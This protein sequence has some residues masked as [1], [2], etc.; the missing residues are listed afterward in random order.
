MRS[1][2]VLILA[3]AALIG[4]ADIEAEHEH[5]HV[6]A[7]ESLVATGTAHRTVS[8]AAFTGSVSWNPV[9]AV[10][11]NA[12]GEMLAAVPA[13][14]GETPLSITVFAADSHTL[15]PLHIQWIRSAMGGPDDVL[16]DFMA[17]STGTGGW[18]KYTLDDSAPRA[19]LPGESL[20]VRVEGFGVFF[21]SIALGYLPASTSPQ[22]LYGGE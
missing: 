7:S 19:L 13:G 21:G 3:L 10:G 12:T 17:T 2:A 8:A 20:T 4:C 16:A 11:Q 14:D 18:E 15:V 9:R 1:I 6:A 22:M 5:E